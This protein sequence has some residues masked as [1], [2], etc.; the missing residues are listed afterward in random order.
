MS[1]CEGV[2]GI[3]RRAFLAYGSAS[4]SALWLK[5]A[6]AQLACVEPIQNDALSRVSVGY[7]P[8][9]DTA[10]TRVVAANSI[11]EGDSAFQ[12]SGVRMTILGMSPVAADSE[13]ASL[14]VDILYDVTGHA[15]PLRVHAWRFTNGALPHC[16]PGN[17]FVVPVDKGRPVRMAIEAADRSGVRVLRICRFTTGSEPELPKLVRG[18]YFLA[19]AGAPA[20]GSVEWRPEDAGASRLFEKAGLDGSA[21]PVK[22]PHLVMT[23]DYSQ[24]LAP[25]GSEPRA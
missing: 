2:H 13:L 14:S 19:P 21:T 1:N 16:S 8:L 18:T 15:E 9:S 4:L 25:L 17:S 20:W 10:I 5:P 22:F 24:P 11:R 7:C 12:D 6:G 3:P 23:A